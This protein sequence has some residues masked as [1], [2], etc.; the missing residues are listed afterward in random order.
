MFTK[1]WAL[2]SKVGKNT[3]TLENKSASRKKKQKDKFDQ[4][5]NLIGQK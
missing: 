5:R 1:K 2:L 3:G 4:L